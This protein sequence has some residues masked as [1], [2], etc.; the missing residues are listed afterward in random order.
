MK[1]RHLWGLKIEEWHVE[2][3]GEGRKRVYRITILEALH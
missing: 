2:K 1:R 3:F